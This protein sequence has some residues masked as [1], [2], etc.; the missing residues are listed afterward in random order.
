M[1][2]RLLS[3][4]LALI[5][6]FSA[7]GKEAESANAVIRTHKAE[8]AMSSATSGKLKVQT[9]I[10]VMNKHGLGAAEF[11]VYNDGFRQLSNFSGTIQAGG[12]VI[13]KLKKSDIS[14]VSATDGIASDATVSVY[15]PT[16]PYP[17]DVEYEYTVDYSKGMVSFP[18]FIPIAE[19]DVRLEKSEYVIAAPSGT[20]ILYNSSEE[21]QV[22]KEGKVD[23]Y[24]WTFD[25]HK[26][27]VSEHMMPSFL[28]LV[29]YV[30][31]CPVDFA[32]GGTKGSQE[33]WN[34]T[35]KWLYS[36]QEGNAVVP[37]ELKTKV[38]ALTEGLSDKGKI[39]AIYDYLRE[40]TRYVSIQLGIGGFKPFPVETVYKTGFGD[41]KA[42]S[43]YMQALLKVVGIDSHY[44][45]ISTSRS[46]LIKNYHSVGQMNHAMLCVPM[47]NDTLWIE[48]TNPRYP[49][50]YRHDSSAGHEV[51]LVKEDGGELVKIPNYPDSLRFRSES[52]DVILSSDCTAECVGSRLLKLDNVEPYLSF[53]S[54]KPKDQFD[55]I[56]SGNSLNPTDFKI[57]SVKDN[58]NSW[59]E[60]EGGF[61]PEMNIDYSYKVNG[62]ATKSGE[63]MFIQ[64][65]PF[66]KKLHADRK[67]R[68]NKMVSSAGST[69]ADTV[70]LI[71][72]KG[73]I[74]E[75]M[76]ESSA[77][78]SKFGT[79]RTEVKYTP[80]EDDRPAEIQAVQTMTFVPFK[81]EPE[82]YEQ[83]RSFAKEVSKAYSAK[84]VL[85]SSQ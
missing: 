62:Y 8:F 63:R 85:I 76:P 51:V 74:P 41:C 69:F 24:I 30:Y 50:G 20:R 59:L 81:G 66:S 83:Y 38:T 56:M 53:S 22:V 44:Y 28:T 23:K 72:P 32:Y 67:Q 47:Q 45:I 48:C 60:N 43:A 84:V 25:N 58:F 77:V 35:G 39:K 7:L 6:P 31:A 11:F 21:P 14:T 3:L 54:Y 10:T 17:F 65:N 5:I 33:T 42:L 36:L 37:E 78:V 70:N 12:K 19:P 2:I 49:L 73:F 61:V 52:V 18:S 80:A 26:G 15:A 16:A 40:N 55:V 9:R 57:V 82:E 34:G 75:T 13:K 64:L 27:Y 4:I 79:F 1:T 29:P 71:L 46:K 68:V